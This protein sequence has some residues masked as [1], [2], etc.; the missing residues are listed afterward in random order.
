MNELTM[1]TPRPRDPHF[2]DVPAGLPDGLYGI[3]IAVAYSRERE[4]VKARFFA[5]TAD[6]EFDVGTTR[7]GVAV[8]RNT[9]LPAMK[10]FAKATGVNLVV[11]E[12]DSGEP[13]PHRSKWP[14]QQ[15]PK[16]R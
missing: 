3:H 6:D 4:H 7:C 12:V 1:Q 5:I 11:K 8:W 10:A 9:L 2:L 15:P 16:Q 13:E 14:R